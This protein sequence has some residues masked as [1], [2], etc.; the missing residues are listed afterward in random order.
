MAMHAHAQAP[1]RLFAMV[2]TS[3]SEIR[4]ID[5]EKD[6]LIRPPSIAEWEDAS[7]GSF[8][9]EEWTSYSTLLSKKVTSLQDQLLMKI[10]GEKFGTR[11]QCISFLL[12]AQRDRLASP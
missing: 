10:L 7:C 2:S 11:S 8:T 6:N 12:S 1:A 9:T 4:W 5:D 3:S